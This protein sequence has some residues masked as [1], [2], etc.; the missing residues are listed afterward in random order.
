MVLRF[1][2]LTNVLIYYF[3]LGRMFH[4]FKMLKDLFLMGTYFSLCFFYILCRFLSP[5]Q[6]VFLLPFLTIA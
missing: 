4:S 6:F 2:V 3:T 5:I 1:V